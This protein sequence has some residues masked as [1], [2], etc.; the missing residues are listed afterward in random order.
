MLFVRAMAIKNEARP[1]S[2]GS[3]ISQ[4]REIDQ[5]RELLTSTT[6]G[7]AADMPFVL[8]FLAIMAF[9][10]GPLVVIPLLA[11]PLIVI[12]GLLIQFPMAKLA[13]EGMREGALRN[14][15]LVETIEGIEDIKALQAEPYFQ[16]Q[17]E[18]THEVSAAVGMK[19]RLWGARLTGW[20]STVSQLTY[21][22][23]LVFGTYL[24]LAGEITTGTLVASSLLSSRTIAPLMQ[25]TM[26][27][28][29][30]QHAKSAM[31]GLNELLKNR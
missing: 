5:V 27:F 25:L 6:V 29:R 22:G 12:P 1:K 18:Q 20:A 10:G 23:M 16:R 15:I 17:W 13:K 26:V 30:W 31:T 3:F 28:S 7:A 11:I 9:I 8:L 21:A 24:V 19:Q 2:T 4:L 14:A